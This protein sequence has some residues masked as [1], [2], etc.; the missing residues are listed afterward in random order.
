MKRKN[1]L[2][3]SLPQCLAK[4]QKQAIPVTRDDYRLL[5]QACKEYSNATHPMKVLFYTALLRGHHLGE[6]YG[7]HNH[8][9][10]LIDY[11]RR[12]CPDE[13]Q[14]IQTT[15]DNPVNRNVATKIL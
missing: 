11:F 14:H 8:F 9:A 13:W 7:E 4:F 6:V 1:S 2:S 10:K 3:F 12:L 5:V 15:L